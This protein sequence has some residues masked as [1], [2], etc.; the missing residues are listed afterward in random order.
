[1]NR[2]RFTTLVIAALAVIGAALLLASRRYGAPPAVEGTALLPVVSQELG[3]VTEIDIR[4]G[5]ASPGVT[6][7]RAADAAAPWTVAQRADYPADAAKVHRLLISLGDAKI[8]ETK[9][10]DPANFAAIGVDD[11]SQAGAQGTEISVI[12]KDRKHTVIV[13]KP[14]GDGDFARRGGENQSYTIAP[15]VSAEAEPRDWIDPKLLDAPS[16]SIQSVELKPPAGTPGYTLHR[17]KP[18]EQGFGFDGAP[19]A[20]RQLVDAKALA[21]SSMTLGGLDAEDV[22]AVGDIDFGKSTQAI[23]T[24]TDGNVIT[25]TGVAV[26]DKRW[27]E[28]QTSKDAALNSKVKNHTFEIASYRYDALFRPLEQLLLPVPKKPPA[29]PGLPKAAAGKARK[30]EPSAAASP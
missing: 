20:G 7:H 13:G 27:I 11:P 26:N 16:S 18:N 6:L 3:A 21:P 9:T 5:S 25:L 28:V 10:S 1:M 8:V 17:L 30:P 14:F 15:G 19:P 24:L 29:K 22:G 12:A 23:Y 2:Q 4:K